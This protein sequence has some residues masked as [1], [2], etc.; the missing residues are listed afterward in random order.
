MRISDW[1]SDV[2][3]SDLLR[4]TTGGVDI[5]SADAVSFHEAGETFKAALTYAAGD[6]RGAHNGTLTAADTSE[7]VP[8]GITSLSIG[9]R[10]SGSV[11]HIF[12]HIRRLRY[13]PCRLPYDQLVALTR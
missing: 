10:H 3:S 9:S 5:F 4:V 1:S 2:C 13:Y 7:A 8:S 12:G 6:F 11:S